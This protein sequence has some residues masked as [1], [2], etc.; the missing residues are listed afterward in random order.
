MSTRRKFIQKLGLAAGATGIL[1]NDTFASSKTNSQKKKAKRVLRIAHITDVHLLAQP[2]SENAVITMF[3][4]IKNMKDQPDFIINTGDTIMDANNQLPETVEE[5]WKAWHKVSEH[6]AFE[7]FHCI[8]NHDVWYLPKEK[9]EQY[10]DDERLGKSWV[11]NEL[12]MN[13][14][15]YSFSRNGWHFICLDSINYGENGVHLD[16]EQINWLKSELENIGSNTHVCVYSHIPILSITSFTYYL[17]RKPAP[18]VQFPR[19]DMHSD[20]NELKALFYKHKNVKLALSGHNHY[21]DD[22]AYLGTTYMCNG[23]VSGNWW[24]GDL[25]EFPP[26]YAIIDL[27]EDG[28]AQREMIYYNWE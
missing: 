22:V 18:E 5:R 28:S 20:Y 8:G 23:A 12:K 15:Y 17:N 9:K 2:K 6:N 11:L 14:R 26:A 25:D 3:S 4:E 10:K 7:T 27:Y 19:G 1:A 13:N 24:G 16:E 21:I